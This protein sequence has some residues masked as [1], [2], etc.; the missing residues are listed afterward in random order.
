MVLW[1]GC[2]YWGNGIYRPQLP[3]TQPS[4]LICGRETLG[5]VAMR[6]SP[7][8]MPTLGCGCGVVVAEG[9]GFNDPN[10]SAP[11]PTHVLVR[12]ELWGR[13][14]RERP[15][16]K[17][18]KLVTGGLG[19]GV[20]LTSAPMQPAY[21]NSWGFCGSPGHENALPWALKTPIPVLCVSGP[22]SGCWWVTTP[23]ARSGH[24]FC[25]CL[26][27]WPLRGMKRDAVLESRDSRGGIT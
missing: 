9:V 20:L 6:E 17:M 15:P 13:S 2:G 21:D 16:L 10:T 25:L 26:L 12:D 18:L 7:P 11:D 5:G 24:R 14:E 8:Q 27:L 4:M 23:A 22:D 1:L 3:R 19:R